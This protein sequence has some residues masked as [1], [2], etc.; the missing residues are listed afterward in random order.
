MKK[1]IWELDMLRGIFMILIMLFH[2][3]YDL[4]YLFGLTEL[5][6]EFKRFLFGIGNDWGGTPFLLISGLCATIGSR[7]IKRGLQVIG[8]GMIISLVTAGMYFLH[9]ADRS[10]IIYFGVL[11][12]I[13]VCMLL[14]P[15]FR[16]LP[17]W[18]ILL[19]GLVMAVAGLYLKYNSIWVDHPWLT[20]FGIPP[21]GFASSDYF[22]LLPNLGY[23]L[24][25]AAVGQTFYAGKQALLPRV[26]ADILPIRI[27]SFIGKNS[28][29][30]YLLHQPIM[31]AAIYLWLM[32]FGG[33]PL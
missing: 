16:K 1:R 21:H 25:G 9:F 31:A 12:C 27:F 2:L 13:G 3:W 24:I 17:T 14:W 29:I 6:T 28:L 30:F 19:S 5:D 10:I 20:V 11:H 8:G 7:P 33:N 22:P 32:L 18:A 15:L 4:V 26:N 23:F